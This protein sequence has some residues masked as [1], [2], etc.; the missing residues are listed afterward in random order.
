MPNLAYKPNPKA[1][2]K[3]FTAVRHNQ[4]QSLDLLGP[5]SRVNKFKW[6]LTMIDKI[7]HY[8]EV[9]PLED[10]KSPAIAKSIVNTWVTKHGVME[11]LLTDQGSNI[12]R[13]KA[14]VE[15]YNTL[16][17]GKIRTSGHKPSTN[18][19]AEAAN[20]QIKICLT[21]Y[22]VENPDSWP[23]KQKQKTF[24]YNTSIN[25]ATMYTPF[26]LLHRREA[27]VPN[28]LVYATTSS[29]YY[30][31]QAHVASKTY[32]ALKSAWDHALQNIGNMQEQHDKSDILI[33]QRS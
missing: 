6:C 1:R 5:V 17:V 7:T 28:N 15:L 29:E 12:D 9:D 30:E 14:I 27:R 19:L 2:L 4:I 26:F 25:K 8:L 20:K 22:V 3:P 16:Q 32:Y 18:G 31:S 10:A 11:E 23:E 24:A 13:S 33:K 21:K